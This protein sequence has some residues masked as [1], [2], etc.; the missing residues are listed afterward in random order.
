M[1]NQADI[2]LIEG[3]PVLIVVDIQKG[4]FCPE[5]PGIPGMPDYAARMQAA[6]DLVK[7]ARAFDIPIVFVQEAHRPNGVDFGRELDGREGIHCIETDETTH[8]ADEVEMRADDYFIR[9]RR[10]S[11]FFGTDLEILLKGLKASTLIL[12]GGLTD[13]CVHYTFVDS[14]QHDYYCRVVEDCVA[15]SS[16]MA[17]EASLRAMEYLQRRARCS[18][19]DVLKALADL[20]VTSGGARVVH[21]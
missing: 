3:Q 4:C 21:N 6:A 1:N 11:C 9:K 19:D 13:V 15:G 17:H 10:Y 2:Q 18:A 8:I 20:S 16:Q 7:A 14:H 5:I 12:V